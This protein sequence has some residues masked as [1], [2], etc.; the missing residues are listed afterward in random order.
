[1]VC[2]SHLVL[3]R[4]NMD[5]ISKGCA[6]G[7]APK[8]VASHDAG[9]QGSVSDN[10]SLVEAGVSAEQEPRLISGA[11]KWFD[12]TR[13]FGFLVPDDSALGDVL[14]HFTVLREHGRRMLPEGTRIECHIVQGKR[15]LQASRVLSFDVST[16]VGVDIDR[17]TEQRVTRTK[18]SDLTGQASEF[19]PVIVKWFNRFK[20]YGF[21]Q[22]PGQTEDIFVHMETMR[23]AGIIEIEPEDSYA[24][25]IAPSQRGLI[26][27]EIKRH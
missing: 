16:A 3:R 22:R 1:M 2:V 4:D 9:Q 20:G 24:A 21:M 17:P 10:E 7:G 26:A 18:P 5:L 13:G 8:D 27:I 15:G 11:V 23:A 14:L 25:R 12:A 19:E 6:M